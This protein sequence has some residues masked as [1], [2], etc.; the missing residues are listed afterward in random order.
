MTEN[1]YA[2]V[3][4]VEAAALAGRSV[5]QINR[6]MKDGKVSVE[7]EKR[8]GQVYATLDPAEVLAAAG[9]TWPNGHV[10]G[11]VHS[12]GIFGPGAES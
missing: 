3:T 8:G 7:Y 11:K 5:R 1:A 12:C 4:R 10:H 9:C 2:R 6:W